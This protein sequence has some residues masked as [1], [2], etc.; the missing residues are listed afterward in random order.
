MPKSFAAYIVDDDSLGF[1]RMF[2]DYGF[3]I[4]LE[5]AADAV[6]RSTV[7]MDT[8]Y[9]PRTIVTSVLVTREMT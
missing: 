6:G 4:A 3:T 9:T 1:N 7:R 8:D 5:D 2:A